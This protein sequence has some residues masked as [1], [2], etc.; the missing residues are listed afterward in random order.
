MIKLLPKKQV[1]EAKLNSLACDDAMEGLWCVV[2]QSKSPPATANGSA[3]E[4]KE[5][6]NAT[7]LQLTKEQE[8]EEQNNETTKQQPTKTTRKEL[9]SGVNQSLN[10]IKK[11]TISHTSHTSSQ[12][13]NI[14]V[15]TQLMVTFPSKTDGGVDCYKFYQATVLAR[16]T[17]RKKKGWWRISWNDGSGAKD[18]K[19]IPNK[20]RFKYDGLLPNDNKNKDLWG[21][22]KSCTVVRRSVD[23]EAR[24]RLDSIDPEIQKQINA[25]QESNIR[26]T[27]E[28]VVGLSDVKK[29]LKRIIIWPKNYPKRYKGRPIDHV[30][31][32]GP[33]GTGKTMIAKA[34]ANA[35]AKDFFLVAKKN[36]DSK[37]NGE[38]GRLMA[39]LFEIAKSRGGAIIFLDEVEGM[40]MTRGEAKNDGGS[41]ADIC[42]AFLTEMSALQRAHDVLVIAATNR[43]ELIDGAGRRRFKER[44]YVPL[45]DFEA[46][47]FLIKNVAA[48][49]AFKFE[50]TEEEYNEVA[51]KT[52]GFS[53]DDIVAIM[54][55]ASDVV[56]CQ[57]CEAE[58]EEKEPPPEIIKI[59]HV[60][61]SN[62]KSSVS[63]KD[64][65]ESEAWAE[66]FGTGDWVS[67]AKSET[68]TSPSAGQSTKSS[69]GLVSSP[70][71]KEQRSLVHEEKKE[72]ALTASGKIRRIVGVG[73]TTPLESDQCKS[74]QRWFDAKIEV[75]DKKNCVK[76]KT[77]KEDFREWLE[78]D[79]EEEAKP[80]AIIDKQITTFL[81]ERIGKTRNYPNKT[82]HFYG[83][84]LNG[85]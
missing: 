54:K 12:L 46:R 13:K 5:E 48:E 66:K 32:F 52:E 67:P 73:K 35:G 33:P 62:R 3:D 79:T 74:L 84:R 60:R 15:G 71:A 39:A 4:H 41:N 18:F 29:A 42:T 24:A 43:P 21:V 30:L 58:D 82:A 53:C 75:A 50:L 49:D 70:S 47:L 45:P 16:K 10:S 38:G 28:D 78:K 72:E 2:V 85:L 64:I 9:S 36:I 83:V 51:A 40:L 11:A 27:L 17:G 19:L 8:K 25:M 77:L 63:I 76:L 61:L 80:K 34:S 20:E 68:I 59:E 22:A 55:D 37:W 44:I 65:N 14:E 26:F 6:I 31:L 7:E 1:S 81:I 57:C 23:V 56:L 69:S